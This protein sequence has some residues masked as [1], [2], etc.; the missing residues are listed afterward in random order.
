MRRSFQRRA[1]LRPSSA[2]WSGALALVLLAVL[3]VAPA[4]PGAAPAGAATDP[5]PEPVVLVPGWMGFPESMNLLAEAF[6]AAGHP[7]YVLNQ[8]KPFLFD[9][10]GLPSTDTATNGPRLAALVDQALAETGAERVD[11]VGYSYG[12]LVARHY[13]KDL[14]GA[15]TVRRY[16][17][18][19]VP[20]RGVTTACGLPYEE[21]GHLCPGTP[22]ILT[23]NRGD[24]TPGTIAYSTIWSDEDGAATVAVDGPVC[25]RHV[26]GLPHLLEPFSPAVV[27]E[28]RARVAGEPCP[29]ADQFLGQV[30]DAQ[31][32]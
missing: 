28:A 19:G 13:I 2:W 23:L 25:V 18:I 4:A 15:A 16:V 9:F 22:F 7:T 31:G 26:P 1:P 3:A 20:Q 27:A 29:A 24:D 11:L 14:G 5:V 17:G 8:N 30:P 21:T 32:P 12:G 10:L 6:R